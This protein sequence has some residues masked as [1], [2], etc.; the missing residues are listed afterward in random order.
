MTRDNTQVGFAHWRRAAI[1]VK[2]ACPLGH[3]I[4][5]EQFRRPLGNELMAR[6]VKAPAPHPQLVPRLGHRVA[7]GCGGH[8]LV[9]RRFK[10]ADER[11][12]WHPLS[13]EPN[14]GDVRRIVRRRDAVERFHRLNHALVESHAAGDAARHNGLEPDRCQVAFAFNVAGLFELEQAIPDG[15]RIISHALEA[16][17]V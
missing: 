7:H 10:Q 8:P 5:T 2:P 12:G 15:L 4:A 13:E 9:E 17:L 3:V 16:A 14:A 6:A 1:D 11:D